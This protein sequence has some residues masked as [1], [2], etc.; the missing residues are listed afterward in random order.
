MG[1]EDRIRQK[2]L[3]PLLPTS[4]IGKRR[5]ELRI[6]GD[7]PS[8]DDALWPSPYRAP[9]NSL[10]GG[11]GRREGPILFY[12]KWYDCRHLTPT[13]RALLRTLRNF[14]RLEYYSYAL[15]MARLPVVRIYFTVRRA[16]FR[17]R[18]LPVANVTQRISGFRTSGSGY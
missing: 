3:A 13:I 2:F 4:H 10:R 11:R 1:D 12:S 5:R 8:F 15:K 14:A 6:L 7:F 16:F 9:R 17:A 18:R